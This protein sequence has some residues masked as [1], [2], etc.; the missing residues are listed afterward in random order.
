VN[1]IR[2]H[3]RVGT[4][5]GVWQAFRR[6]RRSRPFWG[7]LLLLLSGLEIFYTTQMSLGGLHFQL[8]PTGFLSWLI[9]AI[10]AVCGLLLWLSPQQRVFYGIV[11][12]VTAVYS[13]IGVNL[14]GFL[15]GM[16]LGVIGGGLGFAWVPARPKPAEAAGD[17]EAGP[18]GA[19]EDG[20]VSSAR[21]DGLDDEY[22][23][24]PDDATVDDLFTGPLTDVL[25]E[26][27]NPLSGPPRASGEPGAIRDPLPGRAPVGERPDET[28]QPLPPRPTGDPASGS[29]GQLNN[30]PDAQGGPLPRRGGP[31][32]FI[33]IT[34]V[35]LTLA[36]VAL[37]TLHPI[38]PAYAAPCNPVKATP[39]GSAAA[40]VNPAAAPSATPSASPSPSD[41]GGN[42]I[43]NLINGIGN[44]IGGL[45]GIGGSSS[46]PTPTASASASA[47]PS[48]TASGSAKPATPTPTK[49]GA[50]PGAST[51]PGGKGKANVKAAAVAADQPPVG[52]TP[53]RM[54]G[55]KL[56]LTGFAFDGVAELPLKNG[57]T[58]RV[59][60]FSMTKA[61]TTDFELQPLFGKN[62]KRSLKSTELTVQENPDSKTNA[63]KVKFFAAKFT[64]KLEEL[65]VVIPIPLTFTPDFPPPLTTSTMIFHDIDIQLAFVDS[66]QLI[67]KKLRDNPLG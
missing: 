33:I 15:L 27:V 11:A 31:N 6:W 14:G 67:A 52:E 54:T 19:E 59:L 48:P 45:L 65:G 20:A 32:L 8:G 18:E 12:T 29:S 39:S 60:Q 2:Q 3:A 10:L 24:R 56:V 58:I 53:S 25:P 22:G 23:Q 64:G 30:R 21:A 44:A 7:G 47:T 40:G 38:S 61:V 28:T 41:S 46:S 51:S 57:G 5:A 26:P 62:Q 34:L 42:P 50:C 49:S 36:A 43:G 63:R 13:L 9:P 66:E 4:V 16:L 1:V 35:P 55:S 17:G 37:S